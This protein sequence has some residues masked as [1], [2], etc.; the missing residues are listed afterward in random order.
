MTDFA[1]SLPTNL[2]VTGLV[3]ALV[4][5]LPLADRRICSR[6]GLNLQGGVSENPKAERLLG[7][8]QAV[9]YAIFFLYIAAVSY[10]VFFSRSATED[11]QVHVALF[12][13]LKSAVRIDLGFFGIIHTLFTEGPSAALSHIRV[14]S[15][16]NIAQV[17]LNIM[18]FV[19]MGYLLPYLFR[20]FRARVTFRPVLASFLI[21]LAVEN[22]QLVF[23]R[24]FYDMDDL[25]D[26]TLGGLVGQLLFVAVAYVVTHPNWR[27][28]LSAWRRWKKNARSR[29]L[30][31]FARRM[32]LTRAALL[33]SSEEEVWDFYVMKLG[34]R[35]VRQIVP[36]NSPGTD[37]LLQMG[38]FQVEVRCVN[39]E[40]ALPPQ[41]LT[42]SVSRL[43]PVIRRLEENGVD[44]S[45]I[46]QD[47]YTGLRSVH[48]EGPDGTRINVIE[49]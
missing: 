29:T 22:L 38:R 16:A 24:G 47:V 37:M 7:I 6:L 11:Y 44:V 8:R 33:A 17:Y 42:L 45:G 2:F 20:Y 23:R 13:D 18:L 40:T 31:P 41:T 10:L 3:L 43:P 14:I 49:K 1:N 30:Y 15:P 39:R 48:F 34:F 27:K 4:F 12:E 21:S 25:V 35:L 19:P 26:N 9:L 5:V 28:E 46:G 32:A 36:L